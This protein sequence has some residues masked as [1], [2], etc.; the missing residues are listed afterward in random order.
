[1]SR[2]CPEPDP[3]ESGQGAD[4]MRGTLVLKV[5]LPGC[6][7]IRRLSGTTDKVMRK[8]L[9]RMIHTLHEQGR[10]DL[11]NAIAKG[12]LKPLQVYNLWKFQRLEDLPHADEL[13]RFADAWP[14]W[15]AGMEHS[16]DWRTA[17]EGYCRRLEALMPPDATLAALPAALAEYRSLKRA[18]P[19]SCAIAKMVCQAFVRDHL[20]RRHKLWLDLADMKA[21]KARPVR[22]KH[23]LTPD[24]LR[25]IVKQLGDPCGM[26]AWT[27]ATTGMG[28]REYTGPW[29]REGD[30]LRIHGTKT[31]G[32]DRLIPLVSVVYSPRSTIAVFRKRLK[33]LGITPY[34][35]RRTF[36]GLM[37]EAGIPRPRRKLY[38]GHTADDITSLYEWQEVRDY[39]R[40]DA[41]KIRAILGEPE[42]GP[43]LRIQV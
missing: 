11:V 33:A 16:D 8:R 3:S 31:G 42:G 29:E 4:R 26:E 18:H 19:R 22:K 37:V 15:I 17:C 28:W 35:L 13:P 40:N 6:E 23:P 12:T 39:L 36:A 1:L 21:P 34:D 14:R 30:G 20:G 10:D 38:L 9:V 27:M 24:Q 41:A 2:L 7:P 32:R 43:L 5:R 25:A